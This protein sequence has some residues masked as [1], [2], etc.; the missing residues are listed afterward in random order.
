MDV[1]HSGYEAYRV[2]AGGVRE[3][4]S[5]V[6]EGKPGDR[7][8]VQ[9][10]QVE[11]FVGTIHVCH[12]GERGTR[13]LHLHDDGEERQRAGAHQRLQRGIDLVQRG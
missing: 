5:A 10:E 8:A 7:S 1:R 13:G 9:A 3:A 12:A 4:G 11:G 6:D 2:N